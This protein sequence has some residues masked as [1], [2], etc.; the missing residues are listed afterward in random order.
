M[1][2]PL[3]TAAHHFAAHAHRNHVRNDSAKTPYIHHLTE[4]A[5]LVTQSGGSD[6]EIAAAWLHDTV[7]D[8]D[9]T[10]EDIRREF[11]DEIAHVVEGVTDLKEWLPLPLSERKAKQ[12]ERV[13]RE[14]ASLYVS[15]LSASSLEA[16]A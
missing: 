10:I 3:S 4:V 2:T 7:E 5:D 6:Q 8:T 9:T 15:C 13:G 1:S 11:G 12:A 16:P 14:I